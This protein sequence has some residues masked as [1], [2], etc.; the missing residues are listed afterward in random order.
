MR[1]L[2]GRRCN[3]LNRQMTLSRE[4]GVEPLANSAKTEADKY[5]PK[6][7]VFGYHG[8]GISRGSEYVSQA[9]C[10]DADFDKTTGNVSKWVKAS[11]VRKEF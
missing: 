4:K 6:A 11:T 9:R 10:L 5:F 8:L 2:T 1:V 7:R 3:L